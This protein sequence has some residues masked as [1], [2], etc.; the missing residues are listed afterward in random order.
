MPKKIRK[1]AIVNAFFFFIAVLHL[2]DLKTDNF[3]INLL[4]IYLYFIISLITFI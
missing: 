1:G 2:I 4:L 3:F